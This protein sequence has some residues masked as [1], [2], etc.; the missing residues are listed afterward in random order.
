MKV[1][2]TGRKVYY[3]AKSKFPHGGVSNGTSTESGI[4]SFQKVNA[5]KFV[6]KWSDS[7][8]LRPTPSMAQFNQIA[9]ANYQKKAL[10]IDYETPRSNKDAGYAATN[11]MKMFQ[12]LGYKI[13]FLPEN[14]LIWHC[15]KSLEILGVRYKSS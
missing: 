14:L 15:H 4:K 11:E 5:Q 6:E 7:F 1:K 12:A 8:S 3:A 9:E 10:F 13:D 2:A